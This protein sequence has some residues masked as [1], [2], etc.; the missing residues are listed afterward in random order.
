M[1]VD[2]QTVRPSWLVRTI[3]PPLTKVL[4]PLSVKMAG[5]P[6]FRMA[7]RM[8]HVGRRS[9][10]AYV[11]AVGARVKDGKILIPLTFGNQSD[12]VRNVRASGG[13]TVEVRRRS[14]EIG[15]PEFL[16]WSETRPSRSSQ[17]SRGAKRL[18][19]PGHQAVPAGSGTRLAGPSLDRQRGI[20]RASPVLRL[21]T[22]VE[23]AFDIARTRPLS[24]ACPAS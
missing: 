20:G 23:G 17:L 11:T 15:V 19:D 14:Y 18:Q 16:N 4:N 22:T 1:P 13:G 3:I 2:L 5:G 12:W 6:G 21:Q 10:T 7:V 24:W 8:H 9:G